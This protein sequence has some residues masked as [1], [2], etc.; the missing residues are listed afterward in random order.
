MNLHQPARIPDQASDFSIVVPSHLR[1]DWVWQRP[2]QFVSRLSARH[3][4]LFV[5]EPV[6]LEQNTDYEVAVRRLEDFPNVCVLQIA[7]PPRDMAKRETIDL[8]QRK[9]VLDVLAGPV[10][11]AFQDPVQW[12]YDPMAA[13]VFA[14]DLDGAAVVYDCMDELSQFRGAPA[15]L[16]EREARLLAM[17]DVVFTGGPKIHR[18]K[19]QQNSNCFCYGC[20]VEVA[21]F[22]QARAVSTPIPAEVADLRGPVLGY[23]GVVDERMDY[24]LLDRL[25]VS[26]PEWNVVIV[27]PHAKVDPADFPRHPNLH[28]L[29]GRDYRDLPAYAKAFDVCL[30][31]FALNE[32]TE[33]INPTKALEYFATGRPVVSTAI[34]DV[35]EQFSEVAGIAGSHEEFV[36]LCE[37]AIA[38]PDRQK[39]EEGVRLAESRSWDEIVRRLEAHIEA[40][41][42]SQQRSAAA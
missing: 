12:F 24:E 33:F 3:P 36:A 30:M 11:D 23:F 19:R 10:G 14:D 7:L 27:G 40:V 16:V 22:A 28:W 20:G 25:A 38:A 31:P 26:H 34:E 9:L 18:S 1:W 2:Q 4:I 6:A 39:I 37:R 5:E 15:E 13:G 8:W 35:I 41:L 42:P 32:A 21:H 29:G 17:A